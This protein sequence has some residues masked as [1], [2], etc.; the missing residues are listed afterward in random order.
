MEHLPTLFAQARANLVPARVPLIFATTVAKQNSGITE[1]AES[2]L[3][4]HAGTLAPAERKRF[5]AALATLKAAVAAHQHW[6]DTVLVPNAKGDFRLGPKLY[7]EKLRFAL[8]SPLD[9]VTIKARATQALADTRAQMYAIARNIVA[10]RGPLPDH[11]TAEQ[12]QATIAAALDS[13]YA[14]R[15]KRSELENDARATLASATDFV[16]AHDLLGL[17]TAPVN[18]IEMPKFQQGANV[19]YCD[20]PGPLEAKLPTFYAVS[21]I[22]AE[23][24]DAQTTSFLREY[25]RY[26]LHDLSVHE[27]MPGHYVQLAHANAATSTLRAVFYSSPF[28]EGWAVYAEGMMADQGYL[29]ND[30]LFKLTVLKMR[31]RS[32]TNSLLDIGIQTENLSEADAMRMMMDGAFQQERE[33]AGKW[34]RARLTSTQLL[35]YFV[36]YSEHMALR[37]EIKAKWGAAYSLKRYN[38]AVLAHGSPPVRYV[39]AL[40]LG[41]AIDQA[42]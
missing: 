8:D 22:P 14:Q 5:D 6:L 38:E 27:A 21:P 12:E 18:V 3:A 2:M 40:L 25:N 9:R 42:Q 28:V 19:A 24:T 35:S 10:H 17:P 13:T 29:E 15:S 37:E 1:I 20:P 39:R 30:P 31:L 7:D 23:W 11:P 41:K 16:R 36:G 4:P 34:T 33:A 32:I 26:M